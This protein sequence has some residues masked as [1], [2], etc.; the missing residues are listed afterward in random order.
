MPRGIPNKPKVKAKSS[1]QGKGA[2]FDQ[3][4]LLFRP[5]M[6]GL[7]LPLTAIAAVL[8]YGAQKYSE[9]SWQQVPDALR[10]Y[11]DANYRHMMARN[12]GEIYDD[13]SGLP[14][15]AHEACNTLFLIWLEIKA[16]IITNITKFNPPPKR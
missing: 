10:R 14:H 6:R 13:E 5:L 9:D 8:S 16:G 11:E 3:G 12:A 1:S 2:K 15:R 4:K 7:A